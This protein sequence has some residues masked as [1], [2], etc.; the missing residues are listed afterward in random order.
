[1]FWRPAELR[2]KTRYAIAIMEYS[3]SPG[4]FVFLILN[5][6]IVLNRNEMDGDVLLSFP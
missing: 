5:N 4:F 2:I 1:M 6:T 3:V